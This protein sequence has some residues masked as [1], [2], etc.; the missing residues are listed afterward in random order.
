MRKAFVDPEQIVLH[1]LLVIGRGEAHRSPIFA[2]P[3][4][5]ILVRQQPR[6]FD[7]KRF[8][9]QTA[10]PC[11][12]VAGFAVL[13]TE[14]RDGVAEC[15]QEVVVVVVRRPKQSLLASA[16]SALKMR[17]SISAGIARAASLSATIS[18]T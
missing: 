7:A 9:N 15:E 6:E 11:A 10:L 17:L 4:M 2:I 16:T 18:I 3:R 12:I 5:H 8:I 14:M 1:G 13:E